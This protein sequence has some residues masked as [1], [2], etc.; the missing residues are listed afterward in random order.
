MSVWWRGQE[1]SETASRAQAQDPVT[2]I[3]NGRFTM[4]QGVRAEDVPE[5]AAVNALRK[6]AQKQSDLLRE[7]I[8][9]EVLQQR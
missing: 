9:A 1:G 3:E 6:E 8:R 5:S 7:T 2:V 4:R